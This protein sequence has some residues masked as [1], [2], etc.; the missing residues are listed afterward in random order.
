[1]SN[2]GLGGEDPFSRRAAAGAAFIPK[3]KPP[4]D[5]EDDGPGHDN[6]TNASNQDSISAIVD[7]EASVASTAVGES[8][9][10]PPPSREPE[11]RTQMNARV[12]V[13]RMRALKKYQH[14]HRATFQAV[15]DQMVDEYLQRRGL[16]PPD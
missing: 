2:R 9:P 13:D 1:M 10:P 16:L 12:R 5:D 7:K 4:A 11:G 15:V 14:Q 3:A 8:T 6:S